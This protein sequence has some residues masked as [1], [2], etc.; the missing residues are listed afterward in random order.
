MAIIPSLQPPGQITGRKFKEASANDRLPLAA[1][2]KAERPKKTDDESG[3]RGSVGE[4]AEQKT[5]F[6]QADHHAEGEQ[7][8]DKEEKK[9]VDSQVDR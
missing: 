2:Q 5:G 6:D 9:A 8:A 7:K 1:L 3:E 4:K